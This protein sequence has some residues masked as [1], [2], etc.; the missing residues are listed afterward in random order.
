[1][2][3]PDRV[4]GESVTQLDNL[5][6]DN[7]RDLIARWLAL[8]AIVAGL[9]PMDSL[10]NDDRG[11]VSPHSMVLLIVFVF[12]LAVLG[13]A[14]TPVL[15]GQVNNWSAN[16]TAANQTSAATIVSLIPLIFW[17]LIA[18]AIILL[19]VRKLIGTGAGGL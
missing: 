17:I 2:Y 9:R 13:A 8:A 16:L 11:E 18:V 7:R 3:G 12:L 6:L 19:V 1:M 14:F 4:R 5:R 15:Q 10:R